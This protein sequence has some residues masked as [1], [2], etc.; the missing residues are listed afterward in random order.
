EASRTTRLL[1][2]ILDLARL[3]NGQGAIALEHTDLQDIIHTAAAIATAAQPYSKARVKVKA[4]AQVIA[5]TDRQKLCTALVELIDNALCYGDPQQPVQ[6]SLTTQGGWATIQVQD[7]G[8]GIPACCQSDIFEPFY[9]VDEARSRTSG[10]TGL[11]LTLVRSLVEAL[12]GQITLQ[13]Q[14][15]CGSVFTLRIP[16]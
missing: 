3:D 4:W 6:V 14:P 12:A 15:G 16:I 10:G 9:R 5:K 2:E 11:G 1:S 8:A 13:S 7:Y